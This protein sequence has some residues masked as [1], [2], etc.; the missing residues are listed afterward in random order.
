[1]LNRFTA[2]LSARPALC[3]VFRSNVSANLT[4]SPTRS[5][6]RVEQVVLHH[7]SGALGRR[8]KVGKRNQAPRRCH[9]G[10]AGG[11]A[12]SEEPENEQPGS[13]DHRRLERHRGALPH[14]PSPRRA[15]RSFVAGRRDEAGQALVKELRSFG[16]EGEFISTPTSARR[17]TSGSGRQTVA[18]FGRLDVAVN[19]AGTE[20]QVGPIT[21]Q[22]AESYARRSTRMF[23]A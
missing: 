9:P 4:R 16:A 2:A 12:K 10:S 14:S 11:S 20:G 3:R 18:R 22:T 23:S 13:L 6:P 15:Q 17:M 19:N 8:R 7:R 21:D 5:S 1:M